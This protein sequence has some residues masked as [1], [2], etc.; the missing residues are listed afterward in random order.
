MNK[1][2]STLALALM[3]AF[4]MNAFATPEGKS[5][6]K[7]DAKQCESK[8]SCQ[9]DKCDKESCA[10]TCEKKCEKKADKKA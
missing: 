7:A 10:K 3:L 2:M 4:S 5:C 1:K 9:K 8:E 6:N